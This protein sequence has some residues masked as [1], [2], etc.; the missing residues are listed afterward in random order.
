VAIGFFTIEPLLYG[1]YFRDAIFVGQE[2]VALAEMREEFHGAIEMALHS[3]ITLPFILALAGVVLSWFF[4][5]KR[6]DIPAAIK[7][8]FAGIYTLLDNK[9]YFDRFNDW[10]FA[11]GARGASRFLWKYGDVNLIDGVLVNGT[12]KLVGRFAGLLRNLQTGY[13]YHYAFAMITGVFV[14]L[15][16]RTWFE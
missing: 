7:E 10:F 9:Y 15:T 8:R 11:G 1:D 16:V 6:P 4:Y 3:F 12:A 2:H 5:L 13:V 14:L